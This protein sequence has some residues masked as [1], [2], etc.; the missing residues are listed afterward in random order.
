[1]AKNISKEEIQQA[2]NNLPFVQFKEIIEGYVTQNGVDCRQQIDAIITN[3]LQD[4]LLQ[5]GINSTCPEC[6]SKHIG[7]WG[8]RKEIQV[9]K[10]K[11]CGKQFTLFTG[12]I[13]EKTRWHW[14]IWVKVLEMVLNGFSIQDML[15]VL[16]TDYGCDGINPKTVWLWRMKLIHALASLPQ[17]VLTGVIQ[18][19][20]TFVRESQKGS[21]D[22]VSYLPK[23]SKRNPRYGYSPSKLGIM[24][25]EFATIVTAIDN[26]GYCVCKVSSLGKLTTEMFVDLFDAH[27]DNPAWICSDAN[28]VYEA[29]CQLYD[30]PH[31]ER[32][33]TYVDIIRKAGYSEENTP[34]QN[35]R[36]LEKLYNAGAIDRITNK[37]YMRYN[38]F[39]QLKS[40][41]RLSLGRVNALH[42]EIKK[43]IYGDMANVSTKYLQD[44]IGFF[45]YIHNWGVAHGR[46]ANASKDAEDIFIEILKAKV[47]YTITDVEEQELDLPRPSGKYV[48]IL[49]A[50]TEEARKATNNKYFKFNAEDGV[51]TFDKRAYLSAQP[52]SKLYAI[53]KECGLKKYKQLA[54][55]SLISLLLKQPNINEIILQLL[56]TDTKYRIDEED[57]EAM[58]G[59]KYI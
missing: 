59:G 14:E 55:W 27:F 6:G 7:K 25:P 48:A 10:C 53:A 9:F 3:S 42:N 52:N 31:Y 37:G 22:L 45:S 29:Y 47:N 43:F 39:V 15:N 18:V 34:E 21:R 49:D 41:Y 28:D 33:S 57:L 11:D 36:V 16:V 17:P 35:H 24:G 51:K 58:K 19:D 12:T 46:S 56:E 38:E 8:K 40:Q 4:K 2:I 26:R 30:I 32:P 54:G 13:L 44:Y 5:H 50:K 23:G 20:E 1:M